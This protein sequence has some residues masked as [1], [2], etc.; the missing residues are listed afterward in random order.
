[1]SVPKQHHTKT[2]RDRKRVR[3]ELKPVG[4]QVCPKCNKPCLPHRACASCGYYKG[5]EVV[6][7]LKKSKIKSQK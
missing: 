5:R 6:D 3:F 2:R 7:T 1:M 4:T